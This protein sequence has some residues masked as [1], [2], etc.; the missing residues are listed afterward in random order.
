[1]SLDKVLVRLE[2]SHPVRKKREAKEGG[3]MISKAR[4]DQKNNRIRRVA[5]FLKTFS[6]AIPDAAGKNVETSTEQA[7]SNSPI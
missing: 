7:C 3:Q 2:S 1:V 6:A 4:K 5:Y